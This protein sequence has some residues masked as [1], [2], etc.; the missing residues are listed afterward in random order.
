MIANDTHD[1]A[2]TVA[3]AG[4]DDADAADDSGDIFTISSR[5][6][7]VCVLLCWLQS[8]NTGCLTNMAASFDPPAMTLVSANVR[9]N[10][11]SGKQVVEDFTYNFEKK[12]NS[13]L[14]F[15]DL[16]DVIL[17]RCSELESA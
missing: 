17:M 12:A 13:I 10:A 16:P 2:D 3:G 7:F 15:A 11:E 6:R 4:V 9:L 8:L 14:Q 1:A 5:D